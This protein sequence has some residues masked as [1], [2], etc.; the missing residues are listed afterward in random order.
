MYSGTTFAFQYCFL[1]GVLYGLPGPGVIIQALSLCHVCT[2]Q[3]ISSPCCNKEPPP[4]R[5]VAMSPALKTNVRTLEGPLSM[6]KCLKTELLQHVL[7][8]QFLQQ[9]LCISSPSTFSHKLI[10]HPLQTCGNCIL[11]NG[12]GVS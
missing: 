7:T 2:E 3:L 4:P 6:L 12:F 8:P 11:R 5:V 1:S 9:E 10:H